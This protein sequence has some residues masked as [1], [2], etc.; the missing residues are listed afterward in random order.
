[1]IG[2]GS[3]RITGRKIRV[4]GTES[5][6]T[7][8]KASDLAAAVDVP[9]KNPININ[10]RNKTEIQ[11]PNLHLLIWFSPLILSGINYILLIDKRTEYRQSKI[12]MQS[13]ERGVFKIFLL[14]D[15][16]GTDRRG[17]S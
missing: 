7:D 6:S 12:K 2:A 15:C 4:F 11:Q 16:L 8:R 1:M 5:R 10:T 14:I 9:G 13:P 3:F 17:G